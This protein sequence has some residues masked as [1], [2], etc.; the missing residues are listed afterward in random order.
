MPAV[1]WQEKSCQHDFQNCPFLNL[2]NHCFDKNC[3]V[4]ASILL[5]SINGKNI[6][7]DQIVLNLITQNAGSLGKNFQIAGMIF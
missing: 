1:I 3:Q 4:V 7:S 6:S 2:N 5:F